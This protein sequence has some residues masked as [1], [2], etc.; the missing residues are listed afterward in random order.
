MYRKWFMKWYGIELTGK[1]KWIELFLV[2]NRKY[3]K[4]QA[5]LKVHI[6]NLATMSVFNAIDFLFNNVH[7]IY[8]KLFFS[9]HTICYTFL[10]C[11]SLSDD[12]FFP[13]FEG[14]KFKENVWVCVLHLKEN[15]IEID[16]VR[17][18]WTFY[19]LFRFL[20]WWSWIFYIFCFRYQWTVECVMVFC[21]SITPYIVPFWHNDGKCFCMQS[22]WWNCNDIFIGDRIKWK[23][24][25][26][27]FT[28]CGFVAVGFCLFRKINVKARMNTRICWRVKW[29]FF[30]AFIFK[31]YFHNIFLSIIQAFYMKRKYWN[32]SQFKRS[33]CTEINL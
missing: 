21:K 13:T 18:S 33:H 10:L 17:F 16:L 28:K 15:Y 4:N 31:F 29:R 8:E 19:F 27:I 20:I 23:N 6:H 14:W 30:F 7:V 9:L 1:L 25:F 5:P 11:H 12:F 26:V 2:E 24:I 3:K 22:V 32:T